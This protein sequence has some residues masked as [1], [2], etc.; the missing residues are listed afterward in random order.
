M[1][2]LA[3][4][5]ETANRRSDSACSVGLIFVDDLKIIKKEHFF[6]NPGD[7]WFEFTFLHK[8]SW[9]D[10]KNKPTFGQLW[11]NILPYFEKADFAVAHNSGFDKKVLYSCLER[12]GIGFSDFDFKCTMRLARN[13][14]KIRPARLSDVCRYFDIELDHHNALSDAVACAKIMIKAIEYRKIS[15]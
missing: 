7:D 3:I 10:V 9:N 15:N 5:F 14:W 13:L 6:I 12:Y 2:F 11:K 1:K 8:I 4:D